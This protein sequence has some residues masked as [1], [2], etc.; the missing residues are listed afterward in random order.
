MNKVYEYVQ[1]NIIAQLKEAIKNGT[2]VPW[3]KPWI[4]TDGARNYITH[5]SYRGI[6]TLLLPMEGEYITFRQIKKLQMEKKFSN[7][8]LKKG[9][10]SY[11]VVFW[12]F[13]SSDDK[14]DNKNTNIVEEIT[15]DDNRKKVP[16]FRYYR[17]FHISS[18]EGLK[19]HDDIMQSIN[20]N[21]N[22]DEEAE[23]IID[24]YSH[25]VPINKV[26]GGNSSFYDSLTDE[27][28]VPDPKQFTETSE[29]YSTVFHEMVHSTGN[30]KR[31]SRFT[32]NADKFIF[33]SNSYSKEELIA[34]IGASMLMAQLGLSN[35]NI[36]KN[37]VA[38]LESWLN[39]IGNDVT[40]ITFAAQQAQKAVDFINNKAYGEELA[41]AI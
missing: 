32:E 41:K 15:D 4:G 19:P 14:N 25:E 22:T 11:M 10:K 36:N 7:I 23:K 12:K 34:E 26:F 35:K 31:L 29:F 38:Y 39:A 1:Q 24:K 5:K 20:A 21:I 8:K 17:V 30:K 16:I 9:S 2:C 28:T 6:N 33:G 13:Y 37:S 40:L 3:E 27:I 18:V